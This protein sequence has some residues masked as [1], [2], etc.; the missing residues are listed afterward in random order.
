MEELFNKLSISN[1]N[2]EDKEKVEKVEKVEKPKKSKDIKPKRLVVKRVKEV[3]KPN[4]IIKTLAD[5][6]LNQLILKSNFAKCVQGYHL[7]NRSPINETIWEDLNALI[8]TSSEIPVY[9][10]SNGSHGSGMDIDCL[11][12]KISN[13]SAKYA[14]KNRNSFAMSSYRLTTVCSEKTC[15]TMADIIKAINERKNFDYY[16]IMIREELTIHDETKASYEATSYDWLIIP[17]NHAVFDPA[18]YNWTPMIGKRGK[19]KDAQVGWNTDIVNGSKMAITFSMS[20]QLW[21]H[22]AVTEDIKQYIVA[23]TTVAN[24]PVY[25]YI[26]LQDKYGDT[27][28][29]PTTL[30]M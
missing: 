17:S 5:V 3:V 29:A 8:F 6:C 27:P 11:L 7:V 24:T 1:E 23:S 21:V 9:S 30:N 10:Q 18:T 2:N 19:N 14:N 16:S 12:G 25:N 13:K 20:S 22:I 15:G 4:M 28:L 26:E